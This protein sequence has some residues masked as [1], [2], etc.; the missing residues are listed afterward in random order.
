MQRNRSNLGPYMS[1]IFG[2]LQNRWHTSVVFKLWAVSI[3]IL[4]LVVFA[5]TSSTFQTF[6]LA[7]ALNS[8]LGQSVPILG[9]SQ[10]FARITSK[11]LSQTAL[12]GEDLTERELQELRAINLE[13]A[14]ESDRIFSEIKSTSLD[15]ENTREFEINRRDFVTNNEKLF[16]NQSKQRQLERKVLLKGE[17]LRA[18][19]TSLKNQVDLLILRSTSEVLSVSSDFQRGSALAPQAQEQFLIF[20]SEVETLNSLKSDITDIL[21]MLQSAP[22]L[23][24]STNV[25]MSVEKF[26]FRIRSITQSLI[27]LQETEIRTVLAK[28]TLTM[29]AQLSGPEGYFDLMLQ[30][31]DLKNDLTVLKRDQIVTVD[32][33]DSSVEK[34]VREASDRFLIDISLAGSLTKII[35]WIGGSTALFVVS[36]ILF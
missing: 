8:I 12:L 16:E 23:T 14:A 1:G 27:H 24:G 33:I 11:T 7:G 31:R 21:N 29:N 6:R 34:I 9:K 5:Q 15:S 2:E 25:G 32:S 17:E 22:D 28:L 19:A 4:L 36:V 10:E 30:L 26:R 35:G 13:Y 20:A 3:V 18:E